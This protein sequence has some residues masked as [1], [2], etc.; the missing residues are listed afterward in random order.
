MSTQEPSGWAVGGTIFAAS[1]LTLIGMFQ[2]IAGIVAIANDNFYVK[3]PHYTFNLDVT[4][5]GWIH[6]ILGILVFITGL[7]LFNGASWAA[8]G[9]IVIAMLSALDNFFFI[10]YYP[11]WSIG[12]IALDVW[13]IWAL[14]PPAPSR[15]CWRWEPRAPR[16]R[17]PWP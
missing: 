12:I 16:A 15:Y 10:P 1:A 4:A 3:A 5:W 9:G 7:A 13:V 17:S 14:G 2:A 8:V 11:L 6:L